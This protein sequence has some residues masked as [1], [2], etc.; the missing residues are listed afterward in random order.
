MEES[1]SVDTWGWGGSGNFGVIFVISMAVIVSQ[2]WKLIKLYALNVCSLV[3]VNNTS[4]KP[5][6]KIITMEGHIPISLAIAN[7]PK[8]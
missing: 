6:K 8:Y 3:Y 1:R 4:V 2:V 7:I 5:F